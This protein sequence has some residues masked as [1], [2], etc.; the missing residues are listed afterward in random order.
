M[1]PLETGEACCPNCQ[2][3]CRMLLCFVLLITFACIG[4][5]LVEASFTT[6]LAMGL[7]IFG[8][9]NPVVVAITT[10]PQASHLTCKLQFGKGKKS[11]QN[12]GSLRMLNDYSSPKICFFPK[13]SPWPEIMSY[14][15]QH[16]IW[17]TWGTWNVCGNYPKIDI[18]QLSK[19]KTCRDDPDDWLVVWIGCVCLCVSTLL[20]FIWPY[21]ILFL[22]H[23]TKIPT[24]WGKNTLVDCNV[25]VDHPRSWSITSWQ[26]NHLSSYPRDHSSCWIIAFITW[27]TLVTCD[28]TADEPTLG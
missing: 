12:F 8:G 26:W 5:R 22:G 4:G 10:S 20:C 17:R 18:V 15:G 3:W 2:N 7:S 14:I 25:P 19:I 6:A 23:E 13:I 24:C 9:A 16:W 1:Y 11:I 21:I 27:W 28:L